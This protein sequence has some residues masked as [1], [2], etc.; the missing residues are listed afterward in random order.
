[1]NTFLIT[2]FNSR[3][4]KDYAHKFIQTYL[5]TN[6]EIPLV[7][8]V[9]DDYDYPINKNITYIK[10]YEAMPLLLDFK[11]RHKDKIIDIDSEDFEGTQFLQN[12]VKFSHKVFAQAH[13]SY[14]NKKFLFIDADTVF[15]KKITKKFVEVFIPDDVMLTCYGRPN[16]V[17][18]GVVGFNATHKDLSKIFFDLYLSYYL[19]DKI[20]KMK[21]KT[22][23]HALDETRRLMKKNTKYKEIDRGDGMDGHVIYRDKE[24]STFLDHKKGKRKYEKNTINKKLTSDQ[25]SH[26]YGFF[27]KTKV[28][29]KNYLFKFFNKK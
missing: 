10:L 13:A 25:S 22:D 18:A 15:K 27:K 17:E 2:T 19:E 1:M 14:S 12:A 11:K 7:C 6:Q 5:N 9:D 20:F 3:L 29:I 23:C 26:Y 8:Y 4:Y 24:I 21:F 28:I 16:W